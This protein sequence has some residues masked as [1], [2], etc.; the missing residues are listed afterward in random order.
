MK[1]A[2]VVPIVALL[3][4]MAGCAASDSRGPEAALLDCL[5]S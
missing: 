2:L 5:L 1:T 3:L 4:S